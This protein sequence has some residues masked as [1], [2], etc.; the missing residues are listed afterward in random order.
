MKVAFLSYDFGE[1]STRLASALAG[2]AEVLLLLPRQEGAP[3]AGLRASEVQ[4]FP[5][6]KPRL[7]QPVQQMRT[8]GALVRRLGAFDPDLIHLQQGHLWFNLALPLLGRYP[9][10]LTIHDPR[11]HLGDRGGRNTPGAVLRFG[12]RRAAQVIVHGAELR[13][14]VLE[15]LCMAP[16][17]VHD[18]PH[19]A[20]GEVGARQPVPEEAGMILFFG[21]IWEYKGLEYL[22]RAEPLI[23]AQVP[24]LRIAIAGQGEDFARY[25]R[26]MV[27]PERFA[28]YNDYVPD[29]RRAELFQKASVVVL[30]YVEA[31]QSGVI[32]VAYTFAKPVVATTVGG[33]PSMVEHGRTGYLVPPR[34]EQALADAVVRLLKDPGLRHQMGAHARQKLE[35]ECAAPIVARQTLAVYR[36][37]L[38]S[39]RVGERPRSGAALRVAGSSGAP[40]EGPGKRYWRAAEQ[41]HAYLVAH[42]WQGQA[43]V[44]PDPGIR[45]N[46]RIGRF[47][48]SALPGVRWNDNLYYLQAQGYWTLGNWQL[49]ARAGE[50]RYRDLAL[51]CSQTMLARQREDGA[52]EYPNPEWR[53]RVATAEGTWGCLGL[54]ESYRRT[55]DP[56]FLEGIRRW[57]DYL[58]EVIGFQRLGEEL[59]VN[60]FAHW[61]QGER[62]PNNSGFVLRFLAELAEASGDRGYLWPCAG[63]VAFMRGAQRSTGELPYTVPG[64][65]NNSGRPHFQ[66]YQ[67]NAF[68]CL[69]LMHYSQVARD[70]SVFPL[71]E[72]VLGFLGTGLGEDGH[73]HYACGE[74]RRAV[75][76]HTAVLGA[77]F[78][79]AG[80]LGLRGY[81]GLAERAFAHLLGLQRPDGGFPYSRRDYR[82]LNDRRSYPRYLAMILYHLLSSAPVGEGRSAEQEA[83]QEVH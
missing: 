80:T 38:S 16:A 10:V 23:S 47:V 46:Y 19:V 5:F 28:V 68:Q 4:F 17:A 71:I 81:E 18:I 29:E 45:F 44:G 82:I 24:G 7:R 66:C 75:A 83:H 9:L 67:Y 69:D 51:Q 14:Q 31:T 25:R 49:F 3:Y 30:P 77:A 64:E 54:L 21:R 79:K 78:A 57:Y 20:I 65:G 43:L 70:A 8:L 76:Y 13:Q 63:M 60:Y 48:K 55:G 11:C 33:L 1:Y 15:E 58:V 72:G 39:G 50:A 74:P 59:A 26:L 34:D 35:A 53:G 41:L 52:W 36:R 56:R 40:A 2:E 32:P 12:F 73:A 37:A 42:H 27:H 6:H 61:G 62:V 22:I